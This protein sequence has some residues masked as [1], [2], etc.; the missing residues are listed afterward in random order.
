MVEFDVGSHDY[1]T[2]LK[3]MEEKTPTLIQRLQS[4]GKLQKELSKMDMKDLWHNVHQV[5]D[6]QF[7]NLP[8]ILLSYFF[9]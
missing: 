9:Q 2:L 3:K 7:Y 8:A 1:D 6:A 5:E 4:D